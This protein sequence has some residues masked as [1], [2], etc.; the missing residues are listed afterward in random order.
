[1]PP[2]TPVDSDNHRLPLGESFIALGVVAFGIFLMVQTA[3]I[4]VSPGYARIG[5]RVIPWVVSSALVA[6]GLMLVRDALS[7]A[8]WRSADGVEDAAKGGGCAPFG[9]APILWLAIGFGL[10]LATIKV[11]GL[12]IASTLLFAAGARAFGS[13][14]PV[15]DLIVGLILGLAIFFGFNYGL[16]LS[17]PGG[18]L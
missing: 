7:G 1:M 11:A 16:G 10:Y 13:I 2:T 4:P 12:P 8:W 15:T 5:P 6:I 17:L 18:P 3:A 14:R 9:F